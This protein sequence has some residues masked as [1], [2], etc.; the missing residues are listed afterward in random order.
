MAMS[1][2]VEIF[3]QSCIKIN[4]VKK[5]RCRGHLQTIFALLRGRF[6]NLI[7]IFSLKIDL[8]NP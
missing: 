8:L 2:H 5:P 3:L 1:N 7:L 4:W 6:F